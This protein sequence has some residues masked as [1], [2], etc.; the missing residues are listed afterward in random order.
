[1]CCRA[2]RSSPG[3]GASRSVA[4]SLVVFGTRQ[5]RDRAEGGGRRRGD[6]DAGEGPSPVPRTRGG[7]SRRWPFR[8]TAGR[9][10][11]ATPGSSQ[12]PGRGR[13][14]RPQGQKATGPLQTR[15]LRP[16]R[17]RWARGAGNLGLRPLPR[18]GGT[19]NVRARFL[20]AASRQGHP[21]LGP[22]ERGRFII[23][24]GKWRLNVPG[25][26]APLPHLPQHRQKR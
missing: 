2:G 8:L 14:A 26:F 24:G 15:R 18:H 23:C 1:M 25:L 7:T 20:V 21:P 9:S 13:A 12:E 4:R 17:G 3:A 11:R 22:D 16:L 6:R 10:R 5:M 19:E